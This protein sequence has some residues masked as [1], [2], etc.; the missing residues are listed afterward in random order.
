M[1][2]FVMTLSVVCLVW[3]A[4]HCGETL[5]VF[6]PGLDAS[7]APA[8]ATTDGGVPTE[9]DASPCP[10]PGFHEGSFCDSFESATVGEGWTA[11]LTTSGTLSHAAIGGA[12]V[13]EATLTPSTNMGG[14]AVLQWALPHTTR[15]ECSFTVDVTGV[16]RPYHLVKLEFTGASPTE[17][18]LFGSDKQLRILERPSADG[19]DLAQYIRVA[20]GPHHVR[21]VLSKDAPTLVE[22]D[23]SARLIG[24]PHAIDQ[25]VGELTLGI[26]SPY[27]DNDG[28]VFRYDDLF[29]TV[30]P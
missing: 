4:L 29:C 2:R 1:R 25:G 16:G 17:L 21:L 30:V 19:G 14:R 8:D 22:V 9:G 5:P 20:D 23:H 15:V 24:S 12:H 26:V 18:F 10:T 6:D 11:V 3:G 7:I 13:L 27:G 28:G